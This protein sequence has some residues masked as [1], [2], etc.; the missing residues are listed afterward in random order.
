MV[1]KARRILGCSLLL[2]LLLLVLSRDSLHPADYFSYRTDP[3]TG[4]HRFDW[5]SYEVLTIL[6]KLVNHT[7]GTDQPHGLDDEQQVRIVR[8][9]FALVQE[10]GRLEGEIAV[11]RARDGEAADTVGL[12][13]QLEDLRA[14]RRRSENL[15]ENIIRRQAEGVLRSEG[16]SL[17]LPMLQR[18]VMPPVEFEFQSSP[19]FLVI[20]RRDRIER[21]A[22]VS[23][24][25]GL[26]LEQIEEI[27]TT[28]ISSMYPR[29]WYQ[30][31]AL[32]R[33]PRSSLRTPRWTMP[34]AWSPTSGFTTICSSTLSA[35]T[36][37]TARSCPA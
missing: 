36:T 15:V 34:S 17:R 26:S 25:P 23:L 8:E 33:T 35:S 19:D 29:W 5:S 16:I 24:Q 27:E 6:E 4:P 20:S 30:P 31:E 28:Q 3:L 22:N 13:A 14:E 12:Q 10:I 32:G 1:S 9:Y 37:P 7:L 18:W 21:I 11:K 2:A